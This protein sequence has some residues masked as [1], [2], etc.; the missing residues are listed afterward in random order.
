MTAA[1]AIAER[2]SSELYRGD[3]QWERGIRTF[4][5]FI[6]IAS[7]GEGEGADEL[8]KAD[9]A[10][11]VI[12]KGVEEVFRE[13]ARITKG[14]EPLMEVLEFLLVETAIRE[15]FHEVLVPVRGSGQGAGCM[16]IRGGSGW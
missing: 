10:V 16:S 6:G 3:S 2:Y 9:I 7:R 11:V 4:E 8:P 15:V 14:E 5:L 12:V 13:F 1:D